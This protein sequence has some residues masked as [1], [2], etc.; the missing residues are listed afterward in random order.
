VPDGWLPFS[1]IVAN[2]LDLANSRLCGPSKTT[3]GHLVSWARAVVQN[4]H[5]SGGIIG[6]KVFAN[7]EERAENLDI[8]A[9]KT[10]Q[11]PGRHNV[12]TKTRSKPDRVK[13]QIVVNREY[14]NLVLTSEDVAEFDYQP[15][16]CGRS[17]R[18]IVIRQHIDEIKDQKLLLNK[19]RYLF[20]ITND[21]TS[22]PEQIV[23][24]CNDRCEQE[25]LIEQLKNGPRSLTAPV[26]NLYSNWAYLL[27]TSL[28]WSLKAW[29]A[30]SVPETGRWKIGRREEKFRLL[31]MEFQ[32][33]VT[34]M[35]RNPCQIVRTSRRT[36]Y[37]LLNGNKMQPVFWRL[38]ASLQL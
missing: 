26:D 36:I 9:W 5:R 1:V 3:S 30:L 19:E 11:R 31:K 7:L 14:S 22:T 33:F 10:L 38:V 13:E 8:S 28:A 4:V 17:Y 18:M 23:F 32:T 24:T 37:R 25:N 2:H 15:T 29:L 21:R 35:I 6:D 27:L 12:K 34:A 20:Y 16:A